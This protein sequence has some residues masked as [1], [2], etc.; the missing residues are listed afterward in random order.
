MKQLK[1]AIKSGWTVIYENVQDYINHALE[2]ILNK[3]I[4][5][6][7]NITEINIDNDEIEWNKDFSI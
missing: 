3:K 6:K 1:L 7:G 4:I 5:K 2:P